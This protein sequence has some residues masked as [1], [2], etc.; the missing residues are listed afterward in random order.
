M[1]ITDKGEAAPDFHLL[2][3]AHTPCHLI[4]AERP[5]LIDGG[6]AHF[7]N[8][9]I[10][11]ARAVLGGR[12]PHFLLHTHMHFDHCG[13]SAALL[14]AFP[15]LLAGASP[16]GAEII[17]KPRAREL[18][19]TL[20]DRAKEAFPEFAS[21]DGPVFAPFEID[22]VLRHGDEIDLGG[23]ESLKVYSTPG[24]TRDFLTYHLPERGLLIASEA[25]GCAHSPGNLI[26]EFISDY[27]AYLASLELLLTLDAKYLCQG[28]LFVYTDEEVENFLR[29][30][31]AATRRYKARAE[32]MLSEESGDIA[33]VVR[34][35]KAE[36]WDPLSWPKQPEGAYLLNTEG[37]IRHLAARAARLGM[38][39]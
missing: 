16:E 29:E 11:D 18:I 24:H 21:E 23:G 10:A 15:G 9:Y 19:R 33:A 12:P 17:A 13:S 6:M 37:R 27:D 1:I 25:A 26:V 5:V 30:S 2:G 7:A 32:E 20:N 31:I 3:T 28:H 39:R 14:E 34:R 8:R 4:D 38:G 35:V 22:L 36:D